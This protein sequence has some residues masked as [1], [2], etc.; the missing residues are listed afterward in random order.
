MYQIYEGGSLFTDKQIL[1]RVTEEKK[2]KETIPE[3]R[4]YNPISNDQINDK[5]KQPTAKDIFLQDTKEIIKSKGITADLDDTDEGLATEL[6]IAYGTNYI[7]DWL[8]ERVSNYTE[9]K[10]FESANKY[11]DVLRDLLQEVPYKNVY[12]T[13]SDIR[14]DTK[15]ENGIYKS[16]SK[17][18][19]LIGCVEELGKIYRHF[20]DALVD[21][22]NDFDLPQI[23]ED[24]V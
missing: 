17:N 3:I 18:Q 21:I 10:D 15:N 22:K 8:Y 1:Q 12:A 2:I 23:K 16:V 5:T 13:Y 24:E 14:Q 9:K 7:I 6:G 11:H 20:D 19:Y 4:V